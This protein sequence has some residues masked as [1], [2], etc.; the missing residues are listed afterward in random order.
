MNWYV[1]SHILLNR[2]ELVTIIDVVFS[3][4]IKLMV[5]KGSLNDVQIWQ[6]VNRTWRYMANK[7][8]ND[9]LDFEQVNQRLTSHDCCIRRS[10]RHIFVS[11]FVPCS[12]ATRYGR[13]WSTR[14][15]S[16]STTSDRPTGQRVYF[17]GNE[18]SFPESCWQLNIKIYVLFH[19][20]TQVSWS[21]FK[22]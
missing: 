21:L 12:K 10:I 22:I 16:T 5:G 2:A 15:P 19:T 9:H 11:S 4:A 8:E 1:I 13:S 6:I 20:L 14:W 7:Q 17:Q 18:A 3:Q